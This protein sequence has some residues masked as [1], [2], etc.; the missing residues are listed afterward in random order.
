MEE[1]SDIYSVTRVLYRGVL[2]P[3]Q[4]GTNIRN[5]LCM[6][7]PIKCI[8]GIAVKHTMRI[9]HRSEDRDG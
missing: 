7:G 3:V 9:N 1:I 4:N 5:G 2:R 6:N 8:K